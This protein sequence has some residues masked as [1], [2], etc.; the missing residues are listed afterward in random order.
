MVNDSGFHAAWLDPKIGGPKP[1]IEMALA[2]KTFFLIQPKR[3]EV[4]GVFDKAE[5]Q[6][7]IGTLKQILGLSHACE[8]GDFYRFLGEVVES[9]TN[10]KEMAIPTTWER[11]I[12]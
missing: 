2:S 11:L 7:K 9:M 10:S 12:R 6:A 5:A 8:D 3:F 4:L 1:P